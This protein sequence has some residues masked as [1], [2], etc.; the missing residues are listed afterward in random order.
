MSNETSSQWRHQTTSHQNNSSFTK[1]REHKILF[2]VYRKNVKN[3][4]HE[5]FIMS[6]S[7]LKKKI[8][9]AFVVNMMC[10]TRVNGWNGDGSS[11]LLMIESPKN[12]TKLAAIFMPLN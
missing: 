1:R 7:N 3:R 8:L 9:G 4:I 12:I 6:F 10:M 5:I 11:M 2:I